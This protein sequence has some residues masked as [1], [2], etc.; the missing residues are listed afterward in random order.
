VESVAVDV[1]LDIATLDAWL[2]RAVTAS[3]ASDVIAD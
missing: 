2:M 3:T 1:G